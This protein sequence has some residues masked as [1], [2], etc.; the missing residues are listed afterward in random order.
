MMLPMQPGPVP[1]IEFIVDVHESTTLR[2]ELRVSS[3]N[4]NHTPDVTLAA[5]DLNLTK[6]THQKLPLKFDAQIT[7]S[8]YAFICLLKN[9]HVSVHLSEQRVTGVLAVCHNGNK[10]VTKSAVQSPPPDSGID[11]FE[12]WTPKRRP[13]GK[14]L[15]LRIDPPLVVFGPENLTN[16]FARPTNQPNAWVADFGQEEPV[17]RLAWEKPQTIKRIELCFDT[18]F[19]HPMESVLMGHPE[20][21]MPFCVP[22]IA[23]TVPVKQPQPAAVG[24]M[25]DAAYT[26]SNFDN[27]NEAAL[28]SEEP[29]ITI[30]GNH[31]SIR[32]IELQQSIT[33][34]AL[35]LRFKA[36]SDGAPAALFSIRCYAEE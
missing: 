27:E 9:E 14:N 2:V 4:E 23:I 33:T 28:N 25:A 1:Q 35:E 30:T 31:Q 6:G 36:P 12:F 19:D 18:D 26:T 22:E 32:V 3:R 16:G 17:L 13:A 24:A 29:L 11:T 8:S 7:S 34:D 20:R 15:A 5:R 21:V 10:A